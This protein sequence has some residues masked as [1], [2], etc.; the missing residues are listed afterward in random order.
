M[1]KRDMI[2]M[3]TKELKRLQLIKRAIEKQI[4]QLEAAEAC[5]LS[6]RQIRRIISRINQDGDKAVIHR[7]RGQSSNAKI[8]DKLKQ[9]IIALYK[10]HYPDFGPTLAQEKLL[11]DHKIRIS[12][13]TLRLWLHKEG[14]IHYRTR[15]R[16]PNRL[17]RER[18]ECFGQMVQMDGSDHDWLE[19]RG[20]RLVL[21]GYI[22]DATNNVH[23]EFHDYEGTLP[24]MIS[25]YHY[26][27]KYGLPLSVYLDKH[28]T[29]KVNEEPSIEDQLNGK[30]FKTQFQRALENLGVEIIYAHSPQAKGRVERLFETFQDRLVKELR[31]AGA[32]NKEEARKTLS[33]YLPKFNRKFRRVPKKKT[34]LH[35]T[36]P[37]HTRLKQILAIH[38]NCS[39][40]NDNT[41]RCENKIYL[42]KD[43][44]TKNRTK[45]IRV[46]ER[47]NG[48]IHL[49]DK[50][51]DLQYKEVK[52]PPRLVQQQP[53]RPRKQKTIRMVPKDHILKRFFIKPG[54]ILRSVENGFT[55]SD[56]VHLNVK[57]EL[58]ES[59]A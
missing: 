1:Q 26:A 50:D 45:K 6:E 39:L 13:E 2:T 36:P 38:H 53:I 33:V 35:R 9:R 7:S 56:L 12:D 59:N 58:I 19:G 41:I 30:E 52:E 5:G 24:A 48:K 54:S 11:E 42:I 20:P 49:M 37:S 14:P 15:K 16:K 51:R 10:L 27:L 46:E 28:G 8:P 40:M 25:F 4:T 32:K 17:R 31:L 23:A 18:K 21:M 57:K 22:D 47:M 55:R 29:Y 34:D 44:L 43:R 3:T